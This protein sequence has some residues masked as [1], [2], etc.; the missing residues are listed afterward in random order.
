MTTPSY[1]KN[2]KIN[3]RF[4]VPINVFQI[5]FTKKGKKH[6]VFFFCLAAKRRALKRLDQLRLSKSST[7]S[8]S[9]I[10]IFT[11]SNNTHFVNPQPKKGGNKELLSI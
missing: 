4:K 3:G 10:S 6:D 5:T 2:P 11:L 8:I 1:V 7:G 9:L